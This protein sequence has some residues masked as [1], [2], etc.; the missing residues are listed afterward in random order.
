M[1]KAAQK[2][3]ANA[4][5]VILIVCGGRAFDAKDFL[6]AKLDHIHATKPILTII[7]GE[8]RGADTLAKQ[9]AMARH[10]QCVGFPARWDDFGVA[11]GAI[12]NS[13]ML[14]YSG[15][16]GVI[17][18]PGGRGTQDMITKAMIAKLPLMIVHNAEVDSFWRG[19]HRLNLESEVVPDFINW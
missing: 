19:N 11:A 10:V 17:A 18:F 13:E 1:V 7:H 8:A 12:R 15:V 2:A 5:G 16:S 14:K 4:T 6:W 3:T 9:W